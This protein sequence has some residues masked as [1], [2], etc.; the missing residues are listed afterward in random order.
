MSSKRGEDRQDG[1]GG[2]PPP[3]ILAVLFIIS[4]TLPPPNLPRGCI[5]KEG[6][7]KKKLRTVK[8][9]PSISDTLPRLSQSGTHT[10]PVI[11]VS[12]SADGD[13]A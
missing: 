9:L 2:V 3:F 8:M 10:S 11:V 5:K 13:D 4:Q 6:G 12:T 1:E 7:M